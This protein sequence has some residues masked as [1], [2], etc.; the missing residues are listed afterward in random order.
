MSDFDKSTF[1]CVGAIAGLVALVVV[2]SLM[3]GW[4]LSTLWGWFVVPLFGLPSLTIA[5]AIGLSAVVSL[6]RTTNTNSK[7]S[8]DDAFMMFAKSFAAVIFVPLLSVGWGWVVV[9]FI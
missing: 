1:G 4:A 5:Q 3:S 2:G 6:F 9:Q 7:S 8:D